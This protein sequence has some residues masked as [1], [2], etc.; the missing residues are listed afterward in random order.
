MSK[1]VTKNLFLSTLQCRTYGWLQHHHP[2][3]QPASPS[4]R[5]R[6]EEG[7]EIHQRARTLYPDGVMVLGD[8]E[9]CVDKTK[10]LLSSPTVSTIFEA[11]FHNS[12]YITKADILIIINSKW[13][14]VEIKSAVNQSIEHIDD[15]AYTTF[16]AIQSGLDIYR[17]Y[18]T[19][20]RKRI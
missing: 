15:L 12:P 13:K 19:L 1:C 18:P 17:F 10:E 2:I 9:T 7:M 20:H 8:N 3:E 5:L 11:T 4:E 14:I 16:V 6:I